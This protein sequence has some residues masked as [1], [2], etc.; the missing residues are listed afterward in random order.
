MV[1]FL[2]NP[3]ANNRKGDQIEKEAMDVFGDEKIELV[4]ITKLSNS[5]D[6]VKNLNTSDIIVVTG[7]DGTIFSFV[8][9][10]YEMNIPQEIYLYPNGSGNDF[11]HDISDYVTMKNKLLPIKNFLKEL[12]YVEVNGIRKYFINGIGFG[13][14]GYCCEQGDIQREKESD[15]PINYASIAIQGMLGKFHPSNATVTVDGKVHKFKH[16]WLA[17]TMFGRFYGGGMMIAPQQ[18]RRNSEKTVTCV[19]CHCFIPLRVLIVFPNIFKGTHV[20]SNIFETFVG[21]EI[22]VEFDKPQALQIDGETIKNVYSY[23][24]KF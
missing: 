12:P 7:G 18:D 11:A 8:N 10:I 24:V 20:K 6:F 16:V 2:M 9:D 19:I 4:D 15:K 3:L 17:P 1:Y 14:D 22:T 13:I 23:T 21:H 5:A